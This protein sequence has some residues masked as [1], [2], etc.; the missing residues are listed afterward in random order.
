VLPFDNTGAE[1]D[2]VYFADGVTDDLITRLATNPGLMVIARDS[3]FFYKGQSL[4]PR[5]TWFVNDLVGRESTSSIGTTIP[6]R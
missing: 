3:T 2:Q 4:D 6:A 5:A 1:P